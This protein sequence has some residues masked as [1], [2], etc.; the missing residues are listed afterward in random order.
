MDSTNWLSGQ[1]VRP[2]PTHP[3]PE[4]NHEQINNSTTITHAAS[5]RRSPLLSNV[6]LHYVFDRWIN[7]W[8][9]TQSVSGD[10]IVVRGADDLVI[11]FQSR[12]AAERCLAEL[13]K[14]FEK[15]GLALHPEKT[16]LIEFGPFAAANRIRRGQG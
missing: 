3:R 15:F 1:W 4:A 2:A 8:R 7:H 12:T 5:A 13:K 16:R 10:V 11:G 6:F 14:R 9:K